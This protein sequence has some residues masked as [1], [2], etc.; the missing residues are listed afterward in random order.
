MQQSAKWY[1]K[2]RDAE[3]IV[4]CVP[5]YTDKEASKQLEARLTKEAALAN[6][7]VVDVYKEH[8]SRPLGEHLADFRQSLLDKGDTAKQAQ[9][10]T[11]RARAII[12][13][14]QFRM[15]S[16]IRADR[17]E[18][19]VADLRNE[20]KGLSVQTSNFYLQAVQS[21][22]RWMVQNRRASESPLAHLKRMNVK[23]DR[24]HDRTAFEVDEVRRLLAAAHA[25]PERFGMAGQERALLYKLTVESGMRANELRTLRLRSFDLEACKVIVQAA[26]SKH[27]EEDTLPLR[28]ETVAELRA[29]F[30]NRVPTAKAF[31]GRYK[32]LTDKTSKMIQA[33][34]KDAGIPYVDDAGRYRDFHALR[35][36]TGSWLAANGVHPKVAQAIMRHSDINLTMSRYTHTLKGQEAQ[37]IRS[38]PDL[39][40][41]TAEQHK[42]TGTD[43]QI[44]DADGLNLSAWTPKWTP[45]LTPTA[46]SGCDGLS[47]RGTIH[48]RESGRAAS[49][50]DTDGR[51]LGTGT[52]RLSASVIDERE[53]RPEGLEPPTI[54][55]E[56]RCSIQLS[57]GRSDSVDAREGRQA[58]SFGRSPVADASARLTAYYSRRGRR[59]QIKSGR[60]ASHPITRATM[61]VE[62][63]VANSIMPGGPNLTAQ[64]KDSTGARPH[65]IDPRSSGL[66]PFG[67]LNGRCGLFRE[68]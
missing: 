14:C 48:P 43:G 5:G 20:G 9:Q 63:P 17:V 41:A 66:V 4:R 35:H 61:R 38:L 68:S 54:G 12:E 28:P 8:R 34:L 10:V 46:Y 21:L 1:V 22:C 24:R 29:F 13:G 42:A 40:A 64:S 27:R 50:K 53:L 51:D 31:G 26:Y 55:S 65:E 3:G 18:R 62:M 44:A 56:D 57:Y 49:H 67:V 2:Y 60:H 23:V 7:G 25:G 39:S 16:D 19:Y 11:T 15:W 52:D 59:R 6:E 32:W 36:T 58:G 47:S 30:A 37:A 33:D 45:D